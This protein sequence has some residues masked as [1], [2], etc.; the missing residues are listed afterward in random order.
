MSEMTVKAQQQQQRASTPWSK[1]WPSGEEVPVRRA[2]F[3]SM[4]S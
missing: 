3:P 1:S 2:C 4:P